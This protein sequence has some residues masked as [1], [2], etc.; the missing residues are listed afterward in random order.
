MGI[1]NSNCRLRWEWW[2][3]W[4]INENKLVILMIFA[5]KSV[6]VDRET[7]W[8]ICL[9]ICIPILW[10]SHTAL[11]CVIIIL[12][13]SHTFVMAS[14]GCSGLVPF[15]Q[16]W[17]RIESS[18]IFIRF[19]FLTNASTKRHLARTVCGWRA[20]FRNISYFTVLT[21]S[22]HIVLWPQRVWLLLMECAFINEDSRKM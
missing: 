5:V 18:R 9:V 21:D 7:W 3:F 8:I 13:M 12:H 1:Q 6:C 19:R 16:L 17:N 20:I 2:E 10:A 15:S 22:P 11:E 4:N 14:S